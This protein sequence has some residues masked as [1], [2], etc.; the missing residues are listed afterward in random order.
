[1]QISIA[2]MQAGDAETGKQRLH[3][4]KREMMA[5]SFCYESTFLSS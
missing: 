5:Y 1:M 3:D 4:L 2:W